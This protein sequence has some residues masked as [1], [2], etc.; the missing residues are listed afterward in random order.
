MN[1]M[2]YKL[3]FRHLTPDAREVGVRHADSELPAVDAVRL[4]EI[5]QD[6]Q[7]AVAQQAPA[8]PAA[9]EIRITSPQGVFMVKAAN[10]RLRLHSW[11]LKS[12]TRE[13]TVEEILTTVGEHAPDAKHAAKA[14]ARQSSG[15]G[16]GALSSI[17]RWVKIAALVI[18]F[19]TINAVSGWMLMRPPP[20]L[21]PP[22]EMLSAAATERLLNSV[23][24]EFETGS[25]PGDR[26]MTIVR[27]GNV[28]I[29]KYG[30][31][32]D[33]SLLTARAATVNGQEVLITSARSMIEIKD[34]DTLVLYGDTYKRM[35]L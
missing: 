13:M 4:R 28:R 29:V 3:N 19:G 32:P 35:K 24:G 25:R 17:P 16:G 5:L 20:D 9:P 11:N 21:L 34:A 26:W 27:T 10:G 1:P 23:A 30:P 12:G 14:A 22:H 18:L 6:M 33:E 8:D 15:N 2:T 31:K 7:K